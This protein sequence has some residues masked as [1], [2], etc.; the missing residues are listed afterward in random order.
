MVLGQVLCGTVPFGE[1]GHSV[2]IVVDIMKGIRPAKTKDAGN[3]GFTNGLWEIVERCWLADR[4]KRPTLR[5]VLS[6]LRE[7]SSSCGDRWEVV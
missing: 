2:A 1:A 3:L 6:S 7:A 5:A 4:N